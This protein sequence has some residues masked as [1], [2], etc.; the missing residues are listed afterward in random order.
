MSFDNKDY[1]NRK[2]RRKSYRGSKSFDRSCRNHKSCPYCE[3]TRI[4]DK[5]K[6]EEHSKLDLKEIKDV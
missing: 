1:P 5:K 6:V 4:F 2:D 3:G